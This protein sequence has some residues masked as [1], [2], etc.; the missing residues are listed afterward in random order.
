[1]VLR[2]LPLTRSDRLPA[3]LM[4]QILDDASHDIQTL[5]ACSLVCAAWRSYLIHSPYEEILLHSAPQLHRLVCAARIYPTIRDRLA[6]VRSIILQQDDMRGPGL[7]HVF[8][9]M[10]GPYLHKVEHL[11][12][13]FRNSILQPLHPSFFVKLRQ[14]KDIKRLELSITFLINLADFW[15]I[16]RSFP[17]LEELDLEHLQ[18]L[19]WKPSQLTPSH[20]LNPPCVPKLTS[21]RMNRLDGNL[22]CDLVAWLSSGGVCSSIQRLDIYLD[23]WRAGP[24]NALLTHTASTLE[25]LRMRVTASSTHSLLHT[26]SHCHIAFRR[27]R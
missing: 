7:V 14:L 27:I 19:S 25:H 16:V 11:S 9:L 5:H 8:P 17:Q 1:M 6:P 12:F 10:L 26:H 21:V 24:V 20:L 2:P 13:K 22:F 18:Y 15:R 23:N 4:A 3:E